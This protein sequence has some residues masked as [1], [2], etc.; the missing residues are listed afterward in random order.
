MSGRV[1]PSSLAE[2]RAAEELYRQ[3]TGMEPESLS[4]VK[5]ALP[6]AGLVIG[7][8]AGVLY[9]TVRDRRAEQYIHRFRKTSR[10]LLVASSDGRSLLILGGGFQFG[11]RG[12]VDR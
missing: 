1:P 2:L 6:K 8:C 10:P 7:E 4:R 9:D 11:E 3:F 12:I 5:I